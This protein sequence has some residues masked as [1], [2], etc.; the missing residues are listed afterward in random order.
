V[1]EEI[2]VRSNVSSFVIRL[3]ALIDID[4]HSQ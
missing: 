3:Q 1:P 2:S 4:N